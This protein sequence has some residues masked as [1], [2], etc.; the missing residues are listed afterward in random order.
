MLG[1]LRANRVVSRNSKRIDGPKGCRVPAGQYLAVIGAVV[2]LALTCAPGSEAQTNLGPTV[3]LASLTNSGATLIVGDKAFTDFT[4][5]GNFSASQ[6]NV[7][8]IQLS[9]NFGIQFSGAFVSGGSPETMTLGYQVNVTNS[10]NLISAA[11][12]LF[13]GNVTGPTGQVQVT[14]QVFTNSNQFAGQLFVFATATNSVLSA[15]LPIVPPQSFLTVSNSVFLTAQLP[16]FGS[17]STIDQT[18]TQVPEPSAM[19]LVVAGI[20]GVCLLRRRR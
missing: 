6:V 17:I 20:A 11:N 10:L 16:A 12:M 2:A 4:I 15:T 13:N 3:S 9:G 8:P 1:E 14:E 7:T 19:A 18:F 5:G